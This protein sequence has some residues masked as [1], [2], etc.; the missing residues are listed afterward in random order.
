MNVHCSDGGGADDEAGSREDEGSGD[1][2]LGVP[3]VVQKNSAG[4]SGFP[5]APQ[6]TEVI[7]VG[8]GGVIGRVARRA[9]SLLK[10]RSTTVTAT[11]IGGMITVRSSA[12]PKTGIERL[13]G[14]D[15]LVL[16]TAWIP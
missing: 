14:P 3:Q 2:A 1:L 9:C 10:A 12:M 7:E 16:K 11:A 4:P 5:Q 13:T 8:S 6:K 15:T